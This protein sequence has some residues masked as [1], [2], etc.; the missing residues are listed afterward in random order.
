V[1]GAVGSRLHEV[2]MT[3]DHVVWVQAVARDIAGTLQIC[4]GL[5]ANEI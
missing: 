5:N 3:L 4:P 1:G 2:G